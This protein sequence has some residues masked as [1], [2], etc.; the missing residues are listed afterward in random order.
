MP[1]LLNNKSFLISLYYWIG[2]FLPHY[3]CLN[4]QLIKCAQGM[5]LIFTDDNGV[6]HVL[7]DD[8]EL[9]AEALQPPSLPLYDNV[10]TAGVFFDTIEEETSDSC[11]KLLEK[12]KEGYVLAMSPSG[13]SI[14]DRTICRYSR[15]LAQGHSIMF[16]HW[17]FALWRP[18]AP[19]L[20]CACVR[21]FENAE[22][23][24]CSYD[25]RSSCTDAM[26]RK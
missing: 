22:P 17:W 15:I 11:L 3:L 14:R 7:T 6:R 5:S 8:D 18:P 10:N 12:R 13:Q 26:P 9:M 24:H 23:F 16:A 25:A 21:A 1:A 2:L 20:L 19:G 4:C